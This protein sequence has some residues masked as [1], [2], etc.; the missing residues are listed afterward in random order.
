MVQMRQEEGEKMAMSKISN[1]LLVSYVSTETC[2]TPTDIAPLRP[3]QK[4]RSF[5]FGKSTVSGTTRETNGHTL[6]GIK[7]SR[8]VFE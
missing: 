3:T 5:E 8:V 7:H 4:W 1:V 2:L 6:V